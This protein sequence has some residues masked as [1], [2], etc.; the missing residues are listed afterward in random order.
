M[1]YVSFV[2]IPDTRMCLCALYALWKCAQHAHTPPPPPP[3]I[4]SFDP[5]STTPQSYWV[6]KIKLKRPQPPPLCTCQPGSPNTVACPYPCSIGES[7]SVAHTCQHSPGQCQ[8]DAVYLGLNI[9]SQLHLSG[10]WSGSGSGFGYASEQWPPINFK[11]WRWSPCATLCHTCMMYTHSGCMLECWVQVVC[12]PGSW[13]A[14]YHPTICLAIP[15]MKLDH[16]G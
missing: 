16:Q 12:E 3:A 10:S 13:L 5:H 6:T 14:G 1:I 11:G 7:C 8:L 15:S 9:Y 4:P 2:Y